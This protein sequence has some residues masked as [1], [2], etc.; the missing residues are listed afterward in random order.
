MKITNERTSA[1]PQTYVFATNEALA[2]ATNV[3]FQF[4]F[5]VTIIS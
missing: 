2:A 3:F 4:E 5:F 1:V